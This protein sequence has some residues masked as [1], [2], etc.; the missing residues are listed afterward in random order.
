MM[1]VVVMFNLCGVIM[2][3]EF[4]VGFVNEGLFMVGVLFVVVVGISV[5]G[6]LDWYM[7]KV[8]GKSRISAGA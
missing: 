8:L 1:F 6:G 3:V 7:G 2:F 5:M 4:F